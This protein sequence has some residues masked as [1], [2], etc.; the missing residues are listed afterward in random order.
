[1]KKIS[2]KK[3]STKQSFEPMWSLMNNYCLVITIKKKTILQRVFPFSLQDAKSLLSRLL[4]KK[5]KFFFG[6][7]SLKPETS[8]WS[9]SMG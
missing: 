4:K 5:I 1:M 3:T 7:L 8:P 6:K 9:C 2:D